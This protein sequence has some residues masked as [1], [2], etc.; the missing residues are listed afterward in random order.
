MTV[1]GLQLGCNLV[2]GKTYMNG[3]RVAGWQPV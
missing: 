1:T 3:E 2:H